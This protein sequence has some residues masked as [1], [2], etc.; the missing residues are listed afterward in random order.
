MKNKKHKLTQH[1]QE[2]RLAKDILKRIRE[3]KKD[4][5]NLSRGFENILLELDD[6]KEQITDDKLFVPKKEQFS[7]EF[8]DLVT[9]IYKR[10]LDGTLLYCDSWIGKRGLHESSHWRE[11]NADEN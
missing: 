8:G 3:I 6:L 5:V 4:I 7:N 1:Q 9:R 2:R 11:Y 10:D